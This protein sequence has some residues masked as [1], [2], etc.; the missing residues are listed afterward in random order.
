MN[1]LA[2]DLGKRFGWCCGLHPSAHGWVKLDWERNGANFFAFHKWLESTFIEFQIGYVV[3]EVNVSAGFGQW[4]VGQIHS[5]MTAILQSL[6][7]TSGFKDPMTATPNQIRKAITG[8]GGVDRTIK[9]KTQRRKKSKQAMLDAV[10]KILSINRYP[11]VDDDNEADAIGCWL[12]YQKIIG[13]DITKR[14]DK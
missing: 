11:A 3:H 14:I 9:N 6:C 2:L 1:I 4:S 7:C 12:W 8:Y 13:V 5:G 10:N